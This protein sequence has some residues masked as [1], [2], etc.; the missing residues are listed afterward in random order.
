MLMC[1]G[2]IRMD[3]GS[4]CL[5]GAYDL[6]EYRHFWLLNAQKGGLGLLGGVDAGPLWSPQS[7]RVVLIKTE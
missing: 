1:Q 4:L 3:R 7:G 2:H 6:T 5:H